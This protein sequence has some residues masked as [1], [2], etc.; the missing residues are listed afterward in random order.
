MSKVR[1]IDTFSLFRLFLSK[2]FEIAMVRDKFVQIS[3]YKEQSIQF[4]THS[5]GSLPYK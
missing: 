4:L 1:G 3:I 5:Q 2:I